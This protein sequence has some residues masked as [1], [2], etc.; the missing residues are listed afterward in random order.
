MTD[1]NIEENR[2]TQK[3]PLRIQ[4]MRVAWALGRVIFRLIPRPIY[5]PRRLLLRSFGAKIGKHVHIANTAVIYFPWNLDLGDWVAIGEHA[6]IYNLGMISVGE[7]AT[8]SQRVHL[9]AGSHDYCD[10]AML[11]LTPRITIGQQ[12]WICA[13]AFVGPGVSIGEGAVVGARAVAI[14]NVAPW[15]VVAENP[16]RYIKDREFGR[17][18]A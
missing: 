13:D 8:I 4:A 5:G 15:T 7:K 9:C 16:A 12:A 14:K 6:Y 2:A 11:L 18:S 3:Y 10:E 17:S 1:L